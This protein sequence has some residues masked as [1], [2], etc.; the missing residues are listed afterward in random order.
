MAL[1]NLNS[2]RGNRIGDLNTRV[3]FYEY[4]E[5]NGPMPGDSEHKVLFSCWAKVNEMWLKD[6]EVAKAN[7]TMNDLTLVIRDPRS[8]YK[9][10]N[11]HYIAID[12]PFYSDVHY[13]IKHVQPD[14]LDRSYINVVASVAT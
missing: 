4:Q 6:V 8:D 7:G 2:R 5:N 12:D 9:P 11:K 13:N 3:T 1:T 14:V 10:T